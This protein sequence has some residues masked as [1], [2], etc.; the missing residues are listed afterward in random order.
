MSMRLFEM[1]QERQAIL[2]KNDA[3]LA[4]A[5]ADGKRALT[6]EEKRLFE[7]H[8]ADVDALNSRIKPIED[9]NTLSFSGGF[10]GGAGPAA[11]RVGPKVT[12]G[13]QFNPSEHPQA[14]EFRTKFGAWMNN[15]LKMVEGATPQMEAST[16]S[17]PISVG[18]TAGWES[19]AITV[20]TEILP[21]MPSY[22][23]LDS[24]GQAGA[25]EIFTD[26]TR[27]LTKP[28]LSAG[29]P[30]AVFAENAAPSTSQPFGVTGFTFGGTKYARLV[31]ASYESL[32]N[33]ELPLAGAILDELLAAIAT[34]LTS[35][36][37]TSFVSALTAPP[38]VTGASPLAVG[39][40]GSGG[41][42]YTSMIDLRH[43]VPPRFDTPAN[44][45]MLSRATL[46]EIRNTRA[47]S[48]GVPMFDPESNTI[49]GRPFVINDFLDTTAGAGVG[50]VTYGSFADGVFIRK[51]PLMTRVFNELYAQSGQIGF[52]TQQWAD[53]HYL[54]ELAGA[55][56]PPTYQPLF[57]TNIVSES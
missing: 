35:A 55:A 15:T 37:T 46:A 11:G 30:D 17:G 16:P 50:F 14:S 48:S 29:A 34:T 12:P 26:H 21:Y 53:S 22:F 54:A 32:M 8:M 40:G 47:N 27:P 23:A 39:V 18:T 5:E 31:L 13:G 41:S 33:S 6:A 45:W 7:T 28:V 52:R 42:I 9:R 38:G 1:K 3:I 20:P 56:Q 36:I 25:T 43:A 4:R 10:F 24:F 44:K 49:F 2:D 19:I 57:Y 51:T